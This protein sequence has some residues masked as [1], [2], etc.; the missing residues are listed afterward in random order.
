MDEKR[1]L[2]SQTRYA[3]RT[4]PRGFACIDSYIRTIVII[5]MGSILSFFNEW[6]FQSRKAQIL[7]LG[8]DASGKTTILNRLKHND[9][10]VTVPTIGFETETFEKGNL[11][12]CAFDIGGQTKIRKM[13]HH[14]YPNT[15]AI[16][17]IV[18][19]SD[20]TRFDEA[21]DELMSLD[22]HPLLQSIPFL[23]FANKQDLPNAATTSEVTNAMKLYS[24]KGREWNVCESV[25]MSGVGI[26]EGFEWLSKNI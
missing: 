23:V 25:G 1:T 8:L 4:F 15:D 3:T 11:T 13:W 7:I 14:Y 18:D 5:H 16:V 22:A 17:F 21:R 20:K 9:N 10:S 26:D 19:S 12:F 2:R 6:A 24:V